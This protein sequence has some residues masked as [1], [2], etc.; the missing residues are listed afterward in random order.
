MQKEIIPIKKLFK[1]DA[2]LN[3]LP[4]TIVVHHDLRLNEKAKIDIIIN[5]Y[6]K[7]ELSNATAQNYL[8]LEDKIPVNIIIVESS[9]SQEVFN[10]LI[11]HKKVSKILI[12]DHKASHSKY[13]T[14]SYGM[15]ISS[16][17]GFFFSK[18]PYL[19]FSHNDMI[20]LK[21]D[22]LGNLLRQLNNTTRIASFTQRHVIP[23]TGCMLIDRN[24]IT[25]SE[26][27]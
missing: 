4:E 10:K 6:N 22:F 17:V 25:N 13:G 18:S 26:T 21:K 8:L 2:A 1:T 27:D 15:S 19:F 3:V 9:G 11:I 12:E 5:G 14:G 24:V 23:F 7:S 16:A 20:A